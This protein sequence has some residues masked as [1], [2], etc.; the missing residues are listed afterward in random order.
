MIF[1]PTPIDGAFVVAQQRN[2]DSR[3]YFTRTWCAQEFAE[4]GINVQMVQSSVSHNMRR[5]TVRGMHLQVP[6]GLE[7]KLVR[8]SQGAIYDAIV[9]LRPRSPTF[10]QQFGLELSAENGDA[11]YVPPLCLHGFQTL[12]DETQ[13]YY[14]MTGFYAPGCGEGFRWNDPAFG[15]AWPA[16]TQITISERDASYADFDRSGWV[17]RMRG[18]PS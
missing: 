17:E 18:A 7:G 1:T 16:R 5:H 9:D 6:P 2:Q 3:G 4:H 14:M 15:I 12:R 13:V 11:L 10:M 8:C